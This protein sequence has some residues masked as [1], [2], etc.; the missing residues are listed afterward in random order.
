MRLASI[1]PVSPTS[2]LTRWRYNSLEKIQKEN[3]EAHEQ[4]EDSHNAQLPERLQ[5]LAL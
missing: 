1:S 4:I 5:S 3:A 2:L